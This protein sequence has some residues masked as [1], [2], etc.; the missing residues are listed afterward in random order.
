MSAPAGDGINDYIKPLDYSLQY[1][2]IDNAIAICYKL[3]K[4]ALM[5]KVDLKNAFRLCPVRPEDWHLLGIYWHDNFYIDK[6]L[7]FRLRSA[8]FLFNMVADALHWILQH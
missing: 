1:A 3:G 7:P 4:G 6:C 5:A 8:P 2:T